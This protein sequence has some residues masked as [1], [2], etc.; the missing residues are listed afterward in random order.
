MC[1]FRKIVSRNRYGLWTGDHVEHMFIIA[2]SSEHVCLLTFVLLFMSVSFDS[3]NFPG[4]RFSPERMCYIRIQAHL[5][6]YTRKKEFRMFSQHFLQPPIS[7]FQFLYS[8]QR[9]A[10]SMFSITA[11]EHEL[12]FFS[13]W[14][15]ARSTFL[16]HWYISWISHS[17]F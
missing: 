3:T 13:F 8:G 6:R 10:F 1:I 12:L 17:F 9:Y 11:S 14:V 4:V 16:I 7:L 15:G 5:P 2:R